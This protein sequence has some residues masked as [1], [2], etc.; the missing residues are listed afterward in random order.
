MKKIYLKPSTI[1]YKVELSALMENSVPLNQDAQ[2]TT[3]GEGDNIEY[4]NALSRGGFWDD[5]EDY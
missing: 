4:P 5:E 1:S 3:S 2:A